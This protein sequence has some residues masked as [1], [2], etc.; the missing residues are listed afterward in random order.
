MRR[1]D[2]AVGETDQSAAQVNQ[3]AIDVADQAKRLHA[4]V[5]RFLQG[6][7]AA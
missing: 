7:S 5:D 4:T 3:S 1:L 6:V 2:S